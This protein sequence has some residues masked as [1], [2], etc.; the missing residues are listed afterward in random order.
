MKAR[1]LSP[2]SRSNTI[3]GSLPMPS[4]PIFKST[5]D[6]AYCFAHV[7]EIFFTTDMSLKHAGIFDEPSMRYHDENTRTKNGAQKHERIG[8]KQSSDSSTN[9]DNR[10]SGG[11]YTV[12]LDDDDDESLEDITDREGNSSPEIYQG[13]LGPGEMS[14]IKGAMTRVAPKRIIQYANRQD[15]VVLSGSRRSGVASADY[16]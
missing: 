7:P 6:V 13:R 3:S 10:R 2:A 9:N 14:R 1:A 4:S 11:L 8:G 16:I 5:S 15:A 12:D